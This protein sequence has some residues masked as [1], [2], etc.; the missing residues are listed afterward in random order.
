MARYYKPQVIVETGVAAGFSS[1]A[2]LSALEENG[3]GKLYSSDFPYF[4]L[5]DSEQYI[6]VLVEARLRVNWQLYVQG[7]EINL[8]AI[9]PQVKQIDLF[10]YDSDKRYKGRNA[11][12]ALVKP[13]LSANA[14]L[15]M[16]DIQD[17]A[18]FI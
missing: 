14:V 3:N 8:K 5:E 12:Q 18:F 16:D 9:L 13:K 2:F 11:A 6:G 1:Q 15:I 7:D 10:H 4:R 17:N